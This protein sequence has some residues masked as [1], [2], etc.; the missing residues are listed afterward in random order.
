MKKETVRILL[1]ASYA[2]SALLFF[3]SLADTFYWKGRYTAVAWMGTILLLLVLLLLFLTPNREAH[4][5][6]VLSERREPVTIIRWGTK[7]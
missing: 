7:P 2:A 5:L 1:K 6:V 4:E 3:L